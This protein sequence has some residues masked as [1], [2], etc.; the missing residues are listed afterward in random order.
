MARLQEH[1][2]KNV[3]NQLKDKFG[4]KN[5]NTIPKM[6]K[7]VVTCTTKDCVTNGKT[8]EKIVEDLRNVTGQKPVIARAKKSNAAFKLREGMPLGAAVTLR[9]K[10]MYEFTLSL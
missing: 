8:V 3:K 4:Y 9:G 5:V 6:E 10:R 1:Y 7:I 2:E